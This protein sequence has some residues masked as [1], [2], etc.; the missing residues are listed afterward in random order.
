[1]GMRRRKGLSLRFGEW[2][3]QAPHSLFSTYISNPF[4]NRE[5]DDLWVTKVPGRAGGC[6]EAA[7]RGALHVGPRARPQR[8]RR[9]TRNRRGRLTA[10][11]T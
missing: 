9:A 10:L 8:R 11:A 2:E 6:A 3:L 1:M 5:S 7:R 4:I